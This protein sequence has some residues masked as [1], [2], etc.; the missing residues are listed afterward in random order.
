MMFGPIIALLLLLVLRL[1]SGDVLGGYLTPS[2][3]MALGRALTVA[4]VVASAVLVDGLV[5]YFYWHRYWRRRR[6]RQTPALIR[7]ILTFAIVLISLSLGLWWQEGLSFTGLLTASGATAIILGIALQRIIQDLFSGLSINLEGSYALGDWLT[8]YSEHLPEPVYGCVTG[9]TWRAT[10]LTLEDGRHLM[11]PNHAITANAVLNHSKPREAKRFF[12][13]I[14]VDIRVPTQRVAN[15]MQGEMIKMSRGPGMVTSP[16]PSVIIDR[17]SSGAVFYHGRFYAD[18]DGITPA[19]AK[20]IMYHALLDV[21]QQNNLPMPVNQIEMSKP[22]DLTPAAVERRVR[23]ALRRA[24]L[25][26]QVLDD[27]QSEFLANR[28]RLVEFEIGAILIQQGEPASSMFVI[29]EGAARVT[30]AID[31]DSAQE[32]AVLAAGDVVGEMSLMTGATR[33]ATVTALTRLR[34]L[35]IAQEPIAELL[36]NSPE[37]F[38]RFSQAF[39]DRQ[40]KLNDFAK[41]V[42]YRAPDAKDLMTR[43]K[44]FA[45]QVLGTKGVDAHQ[46]GVEDDAAALEKRKP[47]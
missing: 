43:M 39:A 6:G 2:A 5:R 4:M 27:E 29:I 16:G 13:E 30:I 14:P 31:T 17:V 21:I 41:R 46:R 35:E 18:P 26:S 47:Q 33:T 45:S 20:S 36:H 12:V 42:R 38:Q 3:I 7:D 8:I 24:V 22:L 9:M 44:A 28:S 1:W 32:V 15:L 10:F 19:L 37:L 23:N 25:F 40:E 34:T 11:V